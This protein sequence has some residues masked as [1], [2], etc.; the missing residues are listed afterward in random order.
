[1]TAHDTYLALAA[2]AVDYPLALPDRTRLEAH[3]AA[4]PACARRAA[5]YRGD[6]LA[7]GHL[8]AV[9]LPERRG[10]EILAAALHPAAVLHPLRLLVLAALL[11]LLLLGSLAVGA[12]LLRRDDDLAVVLPVPTV[13]PG[14]DASAGRRAPSHASPGRL[15]GRSWP[16]PHG[17]ASGDPRVELV[18]WTAT[19]TRT[20]RGAGSRLAPRRD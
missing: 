2:T 14:P 4:C 19:V 17:D 9:V 7:L 16:S 6:A 20:R 10:S 15:P 3:L 8:P 1:M 18:T 5:A 12:Q 11:G 13:T